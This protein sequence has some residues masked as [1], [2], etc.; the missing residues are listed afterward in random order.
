MRKAEKIFSIIFIIISMSLAM[1]MF[2]TGYYMMTH[3]TDK[4]EWYLHFKD[5]SEIK[6]SIVNFNKENNCAERIYAVPT[7]DIVKSKTDDAIKEKSKTSRPDGFMY[8]TKDAFRLINFCEESGI[9][10]L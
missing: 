9:I 4:G 10:G 3:P 8:R 6:V 7:E 2:S 1:A 5:G